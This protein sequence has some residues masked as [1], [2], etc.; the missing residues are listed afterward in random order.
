VSDRRRVVAVSALA[1]VGVYL[2]S[3]VLSGHQSVHARRPIFDGVTPAVPYKW[4]DPPRALG[5]TNEDPT[6]GTFQ[7]ELAGN[8]S[9]T[10]VLTTDDAQVTL[11]LAKG[12]FAPAK[13]ETYVQV[14]IT[15]LAADAVTAPPSPL[16]LLGNVIRI[17]AT[18]EPSGTPAD[19]VEGT[20]RVVLVYPLVVGAHGHTIAASSDGRSWTTPETNDLPSI[21]QADALIDALGYAAVASTPNGASATSS[22]G[23]ASGG[24]SAATIA[25]VAGLVVLTG[26][27]VYVMRGRRGGDADGTD[28]RSRG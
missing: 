25:I 2:L 28:L 13:D 4:V 9:K 19:L 5:G 18:Y 8:G 3:A 15:P 12:A 7:V 21:Q 23:P 20:T 14:S 24:S 17:E 10:A 27:A 11:I 22:G 16:K 6:S 1:V 26:A